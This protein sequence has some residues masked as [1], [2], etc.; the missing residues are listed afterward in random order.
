MLAVS[1]SD[2]AASGLARVGCRDAAVP[3]PELEAVVLEV[4]DPVSLFSSAVNLATAD[5]AVASADAQRGP[6]WCCVESG[7]CL[8]GGHRLTDR[9]AHVLDRPRRAELEVGLIGRCH[10]ADLVE[11]LA[12]R[13]GGHAYQSVLRSRLTASPPR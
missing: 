10:G 12:D 3:D 9:D 2:V 5:V 7:Q 6:Q 8:P 11:G 4:P 1:V 13:A